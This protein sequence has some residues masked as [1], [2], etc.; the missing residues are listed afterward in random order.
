MNLY[1]KN[2]IILGGEKKSAEHAKKECLVDI[3][4]FNSGNNILKIMLENLNWQ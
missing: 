4:I 1:K 3:R 2:L